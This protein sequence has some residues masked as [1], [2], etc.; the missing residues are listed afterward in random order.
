MT[1]KTIVSAISL[2]VSQAIQI[3]QFFY[4]MKIRFAS[5]Q[6]TSTNKRRRKS[7]L[8]ITEHES[9]LIYIQ[10]AR[11]VLRAQ[12][13]QIIYIRNAFHKIPFMIDRNT[14]TFMKVN[15][16]RKYLPLV[17]NSQPDSSKNHPN[18]ILG[19]IFLIFLCRTP[20][21]IQIHRI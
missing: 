4:R 7:S 20:T 6:T 13:I 19:F 2:V 17:A 3:L 18:S 5:F 9:F 1:D 12:L 16:A 15:V 21:Y 14:K 8:K 10:F 11:Y